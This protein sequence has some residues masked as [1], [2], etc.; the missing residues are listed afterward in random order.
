MAEI[1][2]I[3]TDMTEKEENIYQENE[4]DLLEGL[5]AAADSAANETVKIDIVRNGRHYFSFSIHPLS[6]E[7][8]FAIRKKYTK[9]EKNRRAGVNVASEVDTAKYRS[10]MIYNSTTQEDQEKIWNNKKLWEGLRKQG[11]V[12][13]NALDVVEALL[14]PGEKDK[15]MEAIDDIGGYGSEDL[16]V[17][18]AKN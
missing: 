13:V 18:T 15:I 16:Q 6:E 8:A 4:G 1:K 9:Y 14:K 7:D 5:L 3:E 11:K 12:I 2:A 10:S 17:E